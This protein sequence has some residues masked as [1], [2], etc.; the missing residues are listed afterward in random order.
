MPFTWRQLNSRRAFFKT[1]AGLL[2]KSGSVA[3]LMLSGVRTAAAFFDRQLLPADTDPRSLF[4]KDPEYLDTRNLEITPIENFST[5]GDARVEVDLGT[6]RLGIGGDV[7]KP[8]QLS[9]PRI[10]RLPSV[11]RKVLLVCPG[12]FAYHAQYTG[13]SMRSLLEMCE[14]SQEASRVVFHGRAE[15]GRGKKERFRIREITDGRLFL[16]FSVNGQPLPRQHGFPLRLV[17]EDHYGNRWLKYVDKVEIKGDS[18]HYHNLTS[19][20]VLLC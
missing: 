8:M 11:Q 1:A 15:S 14:V 5:A 4:S 7:R 6:W 9:Y 16:A 19:Y 10:A 18:S 3:G 20:L 13:I 2:V 12:I 17:A